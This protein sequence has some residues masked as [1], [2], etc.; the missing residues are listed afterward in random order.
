MPANEAVRAL[1]A[2]AMS[3]VDGREA[4]K[5]AL[6]I[7]VTSQY[8]KVVRERPEIKLV[9]PLIAIR[10]QLT[11]L[12]NGRRQAVDAGN[13]AHA[14]QLDEQMSFVAE[15]AMMWFDEQLGRTPVPTGAMNSGEEQ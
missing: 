7:G 9:K 1:Y 2:M 4:A 12:S 5:E 8:H 14:Q 3:A 15:G 13:V 6:R 10:R 11:A